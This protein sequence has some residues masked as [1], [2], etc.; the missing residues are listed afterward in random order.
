MSQ[1]SWVFCVRNFLNLTF[2]LTD[3]SIFFYCVFYTWDSLFNFLY[4]IGDASVVPVLFP[5][6][7]ISRIPSVCVFFTASISIFGSWTVLFIPFT[8]LMYFSV[9]LLGIYSFP[10]LKESIIFTGLEL[11]SFSCECSSSLLGLLQGDSAGRDWMWKDLT[12]MSLVPTGLWK[13]RQSLIIP[14]ASRPP[15]LCAEWLARKWA[16]QG[17][18][19]QLAAYGLTGRSIF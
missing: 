11:R 19:S 9:L 10:L 4:S 13:Y 12:W 16:V 6:L 5:R 8:Y 17:Y 1:I 3:G 18:R 7:P 14:A 15:R 2:S